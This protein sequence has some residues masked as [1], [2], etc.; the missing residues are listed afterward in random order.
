MGASLDELAE[1]LYVIKPTPSAA[2]LLMDCMR[3]NGVLS[4]ASA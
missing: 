1:R 2:N 3:L 4:R